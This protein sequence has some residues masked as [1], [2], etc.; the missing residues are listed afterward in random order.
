MDANDLDV[1]V[2]TK[3]KSKSHTGYTQL[4]QTWIKLEHR[5]IGL[6]QFHSVCFVYCFESVLF[7]QYWFKLPLRLVM[8]VVHSCIFLTQI[9]KYHECNK[10]IKNNIKEQELSKLRCSN[11]FESQRVGQKPYG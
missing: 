6:L 4:C 8:V 10:R 7:M 3:V 1:S 11:I 9:T 2:T 5:I